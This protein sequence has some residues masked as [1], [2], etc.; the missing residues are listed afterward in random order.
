MLYTTTTRLQSGLRHH[1][2]NLAS[3]LESA[4]HQSVRYARPNMAA[5]ASGAVF[6]YPIYYV[7]WS[8][9]FPQDY[10]NLLLRMIGGS[11]AST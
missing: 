3:H 8:F 4:A 9:L 11:I 2:W 10:V 6:G 1:F 7:V 5:I